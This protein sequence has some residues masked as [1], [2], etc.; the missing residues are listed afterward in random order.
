[1]IVL[2]CGGRYYKDKT[3][4]FIE[5]FSFHYNTSCITLLINGGAT[6]A[7]TLSTMWAFQNKIPFREFAAKWTDLEAPG[8]VI[9]NGRFGY[10]NTR[11]GFDRNQEMIDVGKPEFVI[12]FPGGNGTADMVK[13]ARKAGL[14][15]LEISE[16]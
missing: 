4:L 9:R 11:A 6:G 10:Y 2:V 7:D 5:L 16:T 3:C 12:A 8:A 13:R 14:T 1:M 15:P